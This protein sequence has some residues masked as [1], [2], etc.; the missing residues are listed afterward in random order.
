VIKCPC[1]THRLVD[2]DRQVKKIEDER[3]KAT[4]LCLQ[5]DAILAER[6]RLIDSLTRSLRDA[7]DITTE[8]NE[9]II[10][11]TARLAQSEEEK[12]TMAAGLLE[13]IRELVRVASVANRTA[14]LPEQEGL[15]R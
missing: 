15:V 10:D 9:I 2:L 4:M 14:T 11:L 6:A 8:D 7:R 1:C 13:Q 12:R 3:D 5:K